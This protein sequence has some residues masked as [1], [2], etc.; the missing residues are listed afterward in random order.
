MINGRLRKMGHK[1]AEL[2]RYW[3][4]MEQT[5]QPP[6]VQ[7]KITRTFQAYPQSQTYPQGQVQQYPQGQRSTLPQRSQS[8]RASEGAPYKGR[9]QP[10]RTQSLN[11]PESQGRGRVRKRPISKHDSRRSTGEPQTPAD[12]DTE[13]PMDN[14]DRV[15]LN[16]HVPTGSDGPYIPQEYYNGGPRPHVSQSYYP[17]SE[18]FLP[19]IPGSSY[20]DRGPAYQPYQANEQLQS[21]RPDRGPYRFD[22]TRAQTQPDGPA[23]RP[24]GTAESRAQ[25]PSDQGPEYQPYQVDERQ[26]QIQPE[27]PL[28][29]M[30]SQII[31]SQTVSQSFSPQTESQIQPDIADR[32]Y[33]QMPPTVQ[34]ELAPNVQSEPYSNLGPKSLENLHSQ[35]LLDSS[36]NSNKQHLKSEPKV[37]KRDQDRS[38]SRD[39]S[40]TK[41]KT[42]SERTRSTSHLHMKPDTLPKLQTYGQPDI[43]RSTLPSSSATQSAPFKRHYSKRVDSEPI[44]FQDLL[45][46]FQSP[47]Q[48]EPVETEEKKQV[49]AE[50]SQVLKT[51]ANINEQLKKEDMP[52]GAR[53]LK[54]EIEE[55]RLNFFYPYHILFVKGANSFC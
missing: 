36:N 40:E 55:V 51:R 38:E 49:Q 20:S 31:P 52:R 43:T 16:G 41:P 21:S 3:S 11:K 32:S 50:L 39:K 35:I 44:N 23:Y 48:E 53:D 19:N 42:E 17:R 24:Y 18:E 26:R 29:Q 2:N 9:D 1:V 12:Q 34:T 7:P 8:Q 5:G 47:K 14:S 37:P 27:G 54:T 15:Q 30:E 6:S 4:E 28:S 25:I 13:M 33:S 22:D 45:V 46:K 10:I